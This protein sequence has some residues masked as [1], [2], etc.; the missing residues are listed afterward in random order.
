[1]YL[2]KNVVDTLNALGANPTFQALVDAAVEVANERIAARE[3]AESILNVVR[4]AEAEQRRALTRL[5]KCWWYA[6]EGWTY[7]PM[8]WNEHEGTTAKKCISLETPDYSFSVLIRELDLKRT[9]YEVVARLRKTELSVNPQD[10]HGGYR[11]ENYGQTKY[12]GEDM[13]T[14]RHKTLEQAEAEIEGWKER[15]YKDHA[16]EIDFCRYLRKLAIAGGAAFIED[17]N[18]IRWNHR[19]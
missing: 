8:E 1:M 12:G 9:P 14:S 18:L 6:G 16:A 13:L 10:I 19:G 2:S 17:D 11:M 7:N 5:N 3:K 15:L 4:E